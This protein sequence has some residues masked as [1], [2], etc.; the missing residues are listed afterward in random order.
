[1]A[2]KRETTFKEKVVKYLKTLPNCWHVKT[3]Q[4][5]LR[6]TPDL[7]I[8]LN[9]LFIGMELKDVGKK[10]TPLQQYS[11]DG[12]TNA[13]GLGL[14]VSLENWGLVQEALLAISQGKVYDRVRLG[15]N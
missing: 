2:Q 4:M 7:L 14:G 5:T 13:G 12:I 15:N 1:M 11:L 8:C 6:G 9:G 3:Q 10:P